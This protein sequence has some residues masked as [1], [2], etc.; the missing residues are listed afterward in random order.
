M[1][2][3]GTQHRFPYRA[4]SSAT[5]SCLS[6]CPFAFMLRPADHLPRVIV[7]QTGPH[8]ENLLP[9][10]WVVGAVASVLLFVWSWRN[11]PRLPAGIAGL[12]AFTAW[13]T[14]AASIL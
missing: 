10:A 11:D 7:H 2:T 4:L 8:P 13:L 12:L 6:L 1:N 9:I 3:L 5:L 14:L